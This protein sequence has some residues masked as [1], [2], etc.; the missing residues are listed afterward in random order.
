MSWIR[1]DGDIHHNH[2]CVVELFRP[3]GPIGNGP[4]HS[5]A[6]IPAGM[7]LQHSIKRSELF[8]LGVLGVGE[9][10]N[11]A[12]QSTSPDPSEAL[13]VYRA[14]ANFPI[15]RPSNS[16]LAIRVSVWGFSTLRLTTALQGTPV[17]GICRQFVQN[18]LAVLSRR[19]RTDA[20]A[21][22]CTIALPG[23]ALN[24]MVADLFD[25]GF[26]RASYFIIQI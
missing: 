24:A 19:Y 14:F 2:R 3:N 12:Q 8:F 25:A 21:S 23:T 17:T 13:P 10:V 11:E 4:Q 7:D 26:G 16:N 15:R 18:R 6:A 9:A 1:L 22:T 5:D 20:E